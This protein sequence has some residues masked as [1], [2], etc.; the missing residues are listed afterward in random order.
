MSNPTEVGRGTCISFQIPGP[1]RVG[2]RRNPSKR[3]P[4]TPLGQTSPGACRPRAGRVPAACRP[5][6]GH[7]RGRFSLAAD[8]RG[9]V[10]MR[11][12]LGAMAAA[13]EGPDG[14]AA[15]AGGGAAGGAAELGRLLLMLTGG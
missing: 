9:I 4:G 6:A 10:R 12:A 7:V 11:A 1:A 13:R 3:Q 8:G 15:G 14:L 5:R 2:L